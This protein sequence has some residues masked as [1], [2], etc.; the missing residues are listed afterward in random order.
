MQ[1]RIRIIKAGS[2]ISLNDLSPQPIAKG[3][4]QLE[5][6]MVDTVKGWVADWHEQKRQLQTAANALIRSMDVRRERTTQ[7][8]IRVH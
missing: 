1:A 6:E 7:Q 4:R 8:L 5:R 2:A 3:D